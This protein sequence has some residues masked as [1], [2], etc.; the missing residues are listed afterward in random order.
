VLA[1]ALN[2]QL[3]ACCCLSVV[4][5]V[6]FH[7]C[8]TT[9]TAKQILVPETL[10]KRRKAQDNAKIAAARLR[11]KRKAANLKKRSDIFK[12][13]HQ[14]VKEYRQTERDQIR[15]KRDARNAGNFYVPPQSKILFVIRLK[16]IMKIAPKPRKVLQ[17]LRL[18][19]INNGVFIRVNKA[20]KQMLQLVEPYV[21]YGEP[22]L[23]S[24]RELIYKRGY[25]KVRGQ[26]I[27]LSDN[28]IIEENL[29]KHNILCM[30]DLIHEIATCGSNFKRAN[31]F[32]WPFKLSNPTGGWSEKKRRH[33]IEGGD[34][35]DRGQ[36]INKLIRQMN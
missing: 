21:A 5:T 33:F 4:L 36:F 18:L 27:P 3:S 34:A 35:G 12:R 15:L 13:A 23:K 17:L 32:L 26:R 28:R 29:S 19:Q 1:I 7:A 20:T 30:E 10:L 9:P 25:G 8:R 2:A 22:N 14:Y 16:G 24:I 6:A 11:Q 31:N